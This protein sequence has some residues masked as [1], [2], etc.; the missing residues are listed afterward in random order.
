MALGVEPK[1]LFCMFLNE[2][3]LPRRNRETNSGKARVENVIKWISQV[4]FG[5]IIQL[6]RPKY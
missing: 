5:Q 2:L 3:L 1:I 4:V 6:V